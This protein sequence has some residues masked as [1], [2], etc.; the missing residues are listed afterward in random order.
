MVVVV[1]E[2][3]LSFVANLLGRAP[4]SLCRFHA[5]SPSRALVALFQLLDARPEPLVL[6]LEDLYPRRDRGE[7][8]RI[9]GFPGRLARIFSLFIFCLI[10]RKKRVKY[11][12]FQICFLNPK[13]SW[14][15]KMFGV[16]L[17]SNPVQET[18]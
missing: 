9:Q 2:V 6:G 5:V 16:G 11:C 8:E 15:R 1:L 10:F 7:V 12:L 3:V 4:E 17:H 13:L 18:P 14:N